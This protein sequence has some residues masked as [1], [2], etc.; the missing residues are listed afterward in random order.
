MKKIALLFALLC[1]TTISLD[2]QRYVEVGGFAGIA[3]YQGD[4]SQ[5]PIEFGATKLS[6]GGLVRYHYSNKLYF[7]GNVYAGQINGDD[8]NAD[9]GSGVFN[10]GWNMTANLLEVSIN[11]EWLP[12]AKSRFNDVGIFRP[13]INPYLFVG[14]GSNFLDKEVDFGDNPPPLN[15]NQVPYPEPDDTNNF[16]VVPIG[17]GLRFDFT[18]WSTLGFEWGWRYT[19]TDYIDG[20]SINGKAAGPDWYFFWGATLSTYF[21]EQEDYGL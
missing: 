1:L 5:D 21:G 7:K 18:Q 8:L 11:A 4:L 6:V 2:A 12:L 13:Q 14:I 19:N 17:G 9:P 15:L 10:R 3:N 20:I 16:L